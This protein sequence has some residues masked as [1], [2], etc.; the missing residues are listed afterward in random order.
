ME[1]GAHTPLSKEGNQDSLERRL[2]SGRARRTQRSLEAVRAPSTAGEGVSEGQE[3]PNHVS[4]ATSG[5]IW[6]TPLRHSL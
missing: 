6:A 4:K 2:I 1:L 5:A 3:S